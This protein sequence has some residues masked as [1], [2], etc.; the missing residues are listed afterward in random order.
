MIKHQE[1]ERF[2]HSLENSFYQLADRLTSSLNPD[3]YLTINLD[4]ERSQFTRFN[5]AKVRQT[6]VVADGNIT[7]SLIFNQREAFAEFPFTG[8]RAVD[9]QIAIDSLSYL[10]DEVAQI[11]EN[12]YVVLP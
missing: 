11:P 5:H 7:I 3:E 1:S 12:P 9:E 10:R 6:G 8:D 2:E 4:S